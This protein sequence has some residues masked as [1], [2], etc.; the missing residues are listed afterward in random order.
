[1]QIQRVRSQE[2]KRIKLEEHAK[3]K[4]A[5]TV[6]AMYEL[7]IILE[8]F[9]LDEKRWT[10]HGLAVKLRQFLS[11]INDIEVVGDNSDVLEKML[12]QI[13]TKWQLIPILSELIWRESRK[14]VQVFRQSEPTFI[15]GQEDTVKT[16]FL[17]SQK[18]Q[19]DDVKYKEVSQLLNKLK[20]L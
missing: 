9:A 1:M 12:L 20:Q 17:C 3:K 11:G 10:V 6:Y 14:F 16:L 18:N 15:F 7:S 5:T 19:L 13:A 2:L 4:A 8:G